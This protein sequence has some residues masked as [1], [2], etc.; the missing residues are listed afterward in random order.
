M[1]IDFCIDSVLVVQLSKEQVLL[2]GVGRV[3]GIELLD[4]VIIFY[5]IISQAFMYPNSLK[6]GKGDRKNR[7]GRE[8]KEKRKVAKLVV[9][10]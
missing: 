2:L 6:F 3:S 5:T 1:D 4:C 8:R 7:R 9:E 10:C